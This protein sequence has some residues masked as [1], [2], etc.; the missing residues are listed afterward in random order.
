M[1]RA[2]AAARAGVRRGPV[3]AHDARRARRVPARARAAVQERADDL[4]DSGR[5]SPA[6]PPDRQDVGDDGSRG[7]FESYAALADTFPFEERAQPTGAAAS[8]CSCASRSASSARSSPGTARSADRPQERARA[9]RGLHGGP[10]VSPEAPGEALR[11]GR[12]RRADRAAAR[13]VQRGHGRPRGVGAARP[14]PA[15]RQDHVHRLDRGRPAR[16]RRSAASASRA[17]RSSSAASRP[18]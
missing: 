6:D 9:A 15:R 12:G 11:R 7:A 18:R 2:V 14:R 16:S 5:V 8:G 3:A 13:R 17:A 1:S 4:A 10:E